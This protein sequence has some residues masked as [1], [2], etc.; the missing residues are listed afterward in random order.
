MKFYLFGLKL[1]FL[2]WF[3]GGN[4]VHLHAFGK[5]DTTR[6]QSSSSEAAASTGESPGLE[7]V[8]QK[9]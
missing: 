1:L 9:K 7:S 2:L 5:E 6:I 8:T 4:I 3:T